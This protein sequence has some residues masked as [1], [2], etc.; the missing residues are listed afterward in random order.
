MRIPANPFCPACFL[1]LAALKLASYADVLLARHA[2]FPQQRTT[3]V[4]EG[5]LR[6]ERKER[7]RRRLL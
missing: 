5:R 3:F 6:D 7:L 1:T 4:G 2:I